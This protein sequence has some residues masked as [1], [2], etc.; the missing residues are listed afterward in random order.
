M[1]K[2]NKRHIQPLPISEVSHLPERQFHRLEQS[3]AGVFYREVF[4]RL[5]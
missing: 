1:F 3:W 2:K 4:S 5:D